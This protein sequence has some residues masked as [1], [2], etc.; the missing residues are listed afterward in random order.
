MAATRSSWRLKGASPPV[1]QSTKRARK[2]NTNTV[3]AFSKKQ[4]PIQS[5][6]VGKRKDPKTD[7]RIKALKKVLAA[8]DKILAAP[9]PPTK[10]T[11]PS[12]E[13]TA[14][15]TQ[16]TPTKT[17]K[18]PETTPAKASFNP[19]IEG[20]HPYNISLIITTVIGN[21]RKLDVVLYQNYNINDIFRDSLDKLYQTVFRKFVSA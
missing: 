5:R 9:F 12:V 11:K 16:V 21:S 8:L 6:G 19:T 15:S 13:P 18:K 3:A 4:T 1:T 7:E 2:V 17:R 20:D 14:L 10:I